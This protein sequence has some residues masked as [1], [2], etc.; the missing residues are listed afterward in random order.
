[1][2]NG[3]HTK[4]P[5][6]IFWNSKTFPEVPVVVVTTVPSASSLLDVYG[7]HAILKIIIKILFLINK[8][9]VLVIFMYVPML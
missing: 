6:L 9:I 4:S 1:L 5:S 8:E 2:A 7:R 3:V